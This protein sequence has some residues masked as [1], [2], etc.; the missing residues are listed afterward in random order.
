MDYD[1]IDV[2]RETQK[3]HNKCL[4]QHEKDDEKKAKPAK[5]TNGIWVG[6]LDFKTTQKDIFK[7]FESCGEIVRLNLPKTSDRKSKGFAYLDFKDN[8]GMLKAI[9]LN[10]KLLNGRKLLIK[11]AANWDTTGKIAR[12]VKG[13]IKNPELKVAVV[14]NLI[15]ENNNPKLF[16]GNLS[17]DTTEETIQ[18]YFIKFGTIQ[19]INLAKF[20]DSGKC[21][22]FAHVD[23]NDGESAAKVMKKIVCGEK[24][25][26]KGREL[27][28]EYGA[29]VVRKSKKRK[30]ND[31]ISV[32]KQYEMHK[33]MEIIKEKRTKIIFTQDD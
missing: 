22:G 27:R 2:I 16:I 1:F 21:K 28:I 8:E 32:A 12:N 20:E 30:S 33:P 14:K 9:E 31:D 10:D 15:N 5:G 18:E 29:A 7:F 3:E 6:N 24:I 11:D 19:N 4:L 26:L 17:F 13:V 23:F 25:F